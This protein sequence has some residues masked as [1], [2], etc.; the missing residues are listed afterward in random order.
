MNT[1]TER[2]LFIGLAS[3]ECMDCQRVDSVQVKPTDWATYIEG[4]EL[5]QNVWP[6]HS[7]W[8]REVL[9]GCRTGVYQCAL[10]NAL[11]IEEA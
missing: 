10:C 1:H 5:V 9:I 7:T 4:R 3:A 6:N 11:E 2:R 8:D